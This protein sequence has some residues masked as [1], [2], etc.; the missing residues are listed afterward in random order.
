[1][2]FPKINSRQKGLPTQ[3]YT[4][5]SAKYSE[6]GKRDQ[7]TGAS[8]DEVKRNFVKKQEEP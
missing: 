4:T 6:T 3:F 2:E 1:M 7:I 8:E 5:I